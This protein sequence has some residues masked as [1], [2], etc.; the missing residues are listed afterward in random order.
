VCWPA[1]APDEDG[2]E[3][4]GAGDMAARKQVAKK[5]RPA[6]KTVEQNLCNINS[7]ESERKCEVSF[8]FC[9]FTPP[10]FF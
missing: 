7:A 8:L 3:E 10:F 4:G 1:A 5:K 6:K 9:F 2:D